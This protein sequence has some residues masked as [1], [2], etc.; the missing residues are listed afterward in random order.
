ML[1]HGIPRLSG[2][3]TKLPVQPL[4]K[5]SPAIVEDT[6]NSDPLNYQYYAA[7]I[8]EAHAERQLWTLPA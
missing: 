1:I 4:G 7:T 2:D 3:Y 8:F 5:I 6:R